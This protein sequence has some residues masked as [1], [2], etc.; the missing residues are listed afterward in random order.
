MTGLHV[1]MSPISILRVQ[2]SFQ[3]SC[4]HETISEPFTK[5]G[6]VQVSSRPC[7]LLMCSTNVNYAST[8]E[9]TSMETCFPE[10]ACWFGLHSELYES[11]VDDFGISQDKYIFS[12]YSERSEGTKIV[13][14][15]QYV[16]CSYAQ[17]VGRAVYWKEAMRDRDWGRKGQKSCGEEV[18]AG[19]KRA[20]AGCKDS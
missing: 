5:M 12:K 19:R 13:N 1:R 7:L 3:V 17:V 15:H 9:Y 14:M 16:T 2:Y 11:G 6:N 20:K 4:S 10:L 18:K 8:E